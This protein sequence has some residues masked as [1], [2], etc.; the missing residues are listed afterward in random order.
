MREDMSAQFMPLPLAGVVVDALHSSVADHSGL[1]LERT[2]DALWSRQA[3]GAVHFPGVIDRPI[4]IAFND[5]LGNV[6][7]GLVLRPVDAPAE[8][9][10]VAARLAAILVRMLEQRPFPAPALVEV[11]LAIRLA[12]GEHAKGT[13]AGADVR[14]LATWQSEQ[15]VAFMDARMQ[16]GFTTADVA[17]QCGMSSARFS[18]AF[19][20][21]FGA[22]IRQWVIQRRVELAQRMLTNDS[23]SLETVAAACGFSEQCHFTRQFSR[24]VGVP[25]GA[26]RRRQHVL[27]A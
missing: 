6:D 19:R 9:M 8:G 14:K 12:H 3:L 22:S 20:L 10:S 24:L 15:A 26:W 2:I 18:I 23:A 7:L 25:P 11:A 5:A 16:E 4:L 21:S 27:T 13:S 1:P 17:A